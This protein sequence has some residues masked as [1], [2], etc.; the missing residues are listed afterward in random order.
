MVPRLGDPFALQGFMD[1]RLASVIT[2]PFLRSRVKKY[3]V[4]A[5]NPAEL[6]LSIQSRIVP[7]AFTRF[8]KLPATNLDPSTKSF[9]EQFEVYG[10][11]KIFTFKIAE[12]SIICERLLGLL[13]HTK[14]VKFTIRKDRIVCY[15]SGFRM[16]SSDADEVIIGYLIFAVL[17]EIAKWADNLPPNS[18]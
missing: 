3:E 17:I 2:M 6:K 18:A 14:A 7:F 16:T 11:S 5:K 15:E 4:S 9:F 12:N 13:Q 10:K 8:A 1:N